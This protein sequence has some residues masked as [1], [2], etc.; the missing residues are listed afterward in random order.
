MPKLIKKFLQ[1]LLISLTYL[2]SFTDIALARE[3]FILEPIV[4]GIVS[5]E[6]LNVIEEN[7][8][9]YIQIEEL[10]YVLTFKLKVGKTFSGYFLD[11][12]KTFEID[13]K[14]LPAED[15]IIE[16]GQTYFSTSFYEEIFPVRFKINSYD[17]RVEITSDQKL[18]SR[19]KSENAQRRSDINAPELDGFENYKFD[20]R[21]FSTPI[22]DLAYTKG[23]NKTANHSKSTDYYQVDM[24][25]LALG[26]DTSLTVFDNYDPFH[27]DS[28][29][30]RLL[31]ERSF[32]DEP[33]NA[34]NLK[35]LKIGD[36]TGFQSNLFDNPGNGRG[37]SLSS[38]RHLIMTAD[39]TI[40]LEGP[41]TAGWEAELYLN[42][43]LI[44]FR[45]GSATGRYEFT[46]IPV[47]Y[48]LNV[49]KIR[50]Y[51]PYGETREEEQRYYSG[52]S[53]VKKGEL[54][55]TIDMY[56]RNRFLIENNETFY[57]KTDKPNLNAT[58]YY[59]LNDNLT[60]IGG[61][62]Q[63]VNVYEKEE[64]QNFSN[65]GMQAVLS[66][67]S[68]QYNALYSTDNSELGHHADLQGNIYIGDILARYEYYGGLES[69]ISF[70]NGE[71][72][73]D[74]AELRLTG[75][76]YKLN[77]PYYLSYQVMNARND[78]SFKEFRARVSPNFW[79]YYNLTVENVM[80]KSNYNKYNYID[81]IFNAHYGKWSLNAHAEY[82]TYPESQLSRFGA[83]VDYRLDRNTFFQF[84]WS[85]H[86][87][88]R[89]RKTFYYFDDH[90]YSS[91][92]DSFDVF[93]I[94]AGKIFDF[95]GLTLSLSADTNDAYS[96]YLTYNISIGKVPDRVQTFTNAQ[97]KMTDQGTALAKVYDENKKPVKDAKLW[98]TGT[99]KPIKTN[100]N[101][102]ALITDIQPYEKAIIK[103]M[104][105]EVDDISLYP[106]QDQ[107]KVVFRPGT[108]LPIDV[109]LSRMGTVEG[110]VFGDGERYTVQLVK[111]GYEQDVY[112]D[113]EGFFIFDDAKYG[114][115]ALKIY[116]NEDQLID[117][118]FI[119]IDEPLVTINEVI[120]PKAI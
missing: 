1:S 53:P 77:V 29:R 110:Q 103:V 94:S 7:D 78:E 104:L 116:N 109:P 13:T 106:E 12:N 107:Y 36:I 26:L 42:D 55:Y 66:G 63:V 28:T 34:L 39:K 119:T 113:M 38:F 37:V 35:Q 67:T 87:T 45:Q 17:M 68:L 43:Q 21:L 58:F 112:T 65:L 97:T 117:E 51:G 20:N 27:K 108:V 47:S 114:D 60:L 16:D 19:L 3:Y 30:F 69:P 95:G 25:M 73:D 98:V 72:L 50:F 92:K 75:I 76:L 48:G 9:Y 74:L 85:H 105:D 40:D 6:T 91:G 120:K 118:R 90:L 18:P 49:F 52:T 100:E 31:A 5:D 99:E 81:T 46:N 23:Y 111:E 89:N 4:Q 41:L 93:S 8:Q 22:F 82:Y 32:L 70:Y 115:Y 2:T 11:P 61:Q 57:N 64:T 44:S 62:S 83:K 80:L 86:E 10:S 54:G 88:L 79:N 102:E 71:F 84:N 33:V 14:K 59:G 96:A 24:S 101:G 56:Q 15:F